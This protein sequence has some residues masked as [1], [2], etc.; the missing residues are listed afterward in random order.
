MTAELRVLVAE[1]RPVDANDG[2]EVSRSCLV[3]PLPRCRY[4]A[5][6]QSR[7]PRS[8]S[9]RGVRRRPLEPRCPCKGCRKSY[10]ARLQHYIEWERNQGAVQ[11]AQGR[12]PT[13]VA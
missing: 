7:K 6:P 8:S 5:P 9:Q 12:Q 13:E 11:P 3:C 4:D 10:E 2:C 1:V